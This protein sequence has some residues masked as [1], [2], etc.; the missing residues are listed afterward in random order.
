MD[1]CRIARA[2][3]FISH[4]DYQEILASRTEED[5]R[6]CLELSALLNSEDFST[7]VQSVENNQEAIVHLKNRNIT[8]IPSIGG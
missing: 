6:K 3:V 4:K 1:K 8:I 2:K 7:V 5:S